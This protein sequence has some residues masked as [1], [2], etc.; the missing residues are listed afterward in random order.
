MVITYLLQSHQLR[1]NQQLLLSLWPERA[2]R[3]SCKTK[4]T[5]L[6]FAARTFYYFMYSTGAIHIM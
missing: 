3:D 4:I 6:D 1:W 2:G 5:D